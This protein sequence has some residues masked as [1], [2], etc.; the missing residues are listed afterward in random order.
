MNPK[1]SPF[2]QLSKFQKESNDYKTQAK[3]GSKD[4]STMR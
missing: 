3:C 1:K 2:V 4:S